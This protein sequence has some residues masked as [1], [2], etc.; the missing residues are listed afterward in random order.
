MDPGAEFV[1]NV[2]LVYNDRE[3]EVLIIN[4]LG[5]DTLICIKLELNDIPE[6]NKDAQLTDLYIHVCKERGRK[7]AVIL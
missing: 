3:Q 7:H 4:D 5:D 6:D 1:S 2:D